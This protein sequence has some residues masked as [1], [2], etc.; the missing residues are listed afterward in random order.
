MRYL[1]V[2]ISAITLLL[3]INLDA[4][5]NITR[6][7]EF[8]QDVTV[9]EINL[10]SFSFGISGNLSP[11]KHAFHFKN[12][13][14]SGQYDS[15]SI[16]VGR[17]EIALLSTPEQF[18]SK[19]GAGNSVLMG[20]EDF[21][22]D[23]KCKIDSLY[24]A[25]LR[26]SDENEV[27]YFL[28]EYYINQRKLDCA[29]RDISLFELKAIEKT[30]K[31]SGIIEV[32]R[33]ENITILV[34]KIDSTGKKIRRTWTFSTK[35][36]GRWETLYGANIIPNY[37][38]NNNHFFSK[39]ISGDSIFVIT[40]QNSPPAL[41]WNVAAIFTWIPYDSYSKK[42]YFT[43]SFGLG[44]DT[45]AFSIFGG[46]SY[47]FSSNISLNIG[48]AGHYI[49]RLNGKYSEGEELSELLEFDQL[50]QRTVGLDPYI[51]VS[52]KFD[53]GFTLKKE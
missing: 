19:I 24:L 31:F 12:V 49:S 50:H 8:G 47:V 23:E 20:N 4:Q 35:P 11:G 45:Q 36:R 42:S 34:S 48:I 7:P 17:E 41:D 29:P 30:N 38:S 3:S 53:K 9:H 15:V 1:I 13:A 6:P 46:M 33:G 26:L 18:I 16:T 2:F 22:P 5:N 28:D 43:Y 21:N 44:T 40:K 10:A 32:E 39:D 25:F 14:P 51:G 52:F 37:I 27:Q